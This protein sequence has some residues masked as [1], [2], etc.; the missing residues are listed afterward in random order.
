VPR[1]K[2]PITRALEVASEQAR[3]LSGPANIV[4]VS[5]GQETCGG[6]PC[7]LVRRLRAQG[8]GITV[9]VVGFDVTETERGQLE[10]IAE[11]RRPTRRTC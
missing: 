8:I 4:L 5:D 7:A 2:S 10:C 6:D 3:G 1:G 11:G 9:H